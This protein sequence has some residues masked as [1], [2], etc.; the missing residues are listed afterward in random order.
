MCISPTLIPN[1]NY[2]F[3]GRYAF[4]KDTVSRF[5]KVPCGQCGECVATRQLSIVQ[6]CSLE[7]L[8]G[9]PFFVTL[10]YNNESLPILETSDGYKIR[11][12]DLS[13]FQNMVKRIRKYDLFGR[14]FRHFTVSEL[15]SK[16]ARPHLHSI[17]F[18]ER[19][20]EDT[21]Y[22]P[23]QLESKLYQVVLSQWKR[24][25]GSSRKPI[26][27]PLC[28]YIQ[29]FQCGK[30]KSTYDLHYISPSTLDG[31]TMDVPFYVTKY[32]LK[33]SSKAKR[34]QQALRLNLSEDEYE[35]VWNKVKP[36]WI[37]SLNFGFGVYDYQAKSMTKQDRL[38]MLSRTKSFEVVKESISRSRRCQDLPKF[39]D[40]ESG[41]T[42]PLS[43]YWKTFGNLY[44]PDDALHFFYN[45]PNQ[46]ADNVTIDERPF[47]SKL[48][49]EESYNR[50]ISQID[51]HQD[52]QNLL[53]E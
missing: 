52:N 18:L 21:V 12:A 40:P 36:R 19:L 4:L 32:M 49:V 20:P 25:Y 9:W 42:Y 44:T 11:Y 47:T 35:H 41:R 16:R 31:T 51:A 26:Y 34:L 28:T 39:Y 45:A 2:G 6:R 22:T 23:Y 33:P 46:R 29:K 5:I 38:D 17:L 8:S 10:T 48:L 15:G 14:R 1:P 7:S 43:R 13:D 50:R 24:N 53:F 30:I 27:K 37:S 3:T